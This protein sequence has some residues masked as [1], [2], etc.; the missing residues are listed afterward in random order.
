VDERRAQPTI[1]DVAELAGVSK[2]TVSNVIRGSTGISTGTKRRVLEA[3]EL[4]G[5]RPNAIARNLVQRRTTTVGIVVGDL[6]NPFYSELAK[7]VEQRL[8]A[9]GYTSMICNTDGRPESE[10]ARVESLLEHRVAGI[11][12]L[13]LSG[14]SG[15][16]P[17]LR[18]QR[19]PLVVASC[20]VERSDCV[21]VDDSRG[22]ALAVRHLIRLGH[23]RIAYL[24]SGFVEQ[25]ADDA[26]FDGFRRALGPL[27]EPAVLRWEH[28]AYLRS[29]HDL[30]AEL[31]R[32]LGTEHPPTAFFVSNDLVA[33][34]LIEA[35]EQLG[36]RVPDDVSVVGFDD[37]ALA[38]LARVSLTTVA[39]PRERLAQIALEIL[40]DRIATVEREPF[41]RVRLAPRLIVRGSTAPVSSG[42]R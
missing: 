15:I 25:Q 31:E 39:Q 1:L 12:M 19:I 40:L 26:R 6:A 5:Y 23:R 9:A 11:I 2:S 16:L 14:E 35:L 3:I 37:I 10:R 27:R 21:A 32:L 20:W 13:Q 38:G 4:V 41:R 7:L 22:A 28:P 30:S 34:D 17:E 24:S 29:D 8:S 18:A 36:R 42:A 33:V